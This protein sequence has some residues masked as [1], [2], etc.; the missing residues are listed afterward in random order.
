MP[1]VYYGLF[2]FIGLSW[3]G[4]VKL[5]MEGMAGNISISE[6]QLLL[7]GWFGHRFD[8]VADFT[9][10]GWFDSQILVA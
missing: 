2:P 10:R 7:V 8:S 6:R 9:R 1:T 3:A 4:I 5:A